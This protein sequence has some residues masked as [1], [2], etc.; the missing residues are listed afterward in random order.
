MKMEKERIWKSL[1]ADS[2]KARL[3]RAGLVVFGVFSL[4]YLVGTLV[5]APMLADAAGLEPGSY[6]PVAFRTA[7]SQN[8][9]A[10]TARRQTAK[11]RSGSVAWSN[12]AEPAVMISVAP[13]RGTKEKATEEKPKRKKHR[14]RTQTEEQRSRAEEEAIRRANNYDPD[15]DG[16]RHHDPDDGEPV[17][18]RRADPDDGDGNG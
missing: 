10:G 9:K 14:I 17:D 8:E 13:S 3:L 16:P 2:P 4:S 6:K 11:S 7:G 15:V 18:H 5:L 12:M 1:R